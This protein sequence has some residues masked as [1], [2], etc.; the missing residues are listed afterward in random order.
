MIVLPLLERSV[1]SGFPSHGF[2]EDCAAA[3]GASAV[4]RIARETNSLLFIA[5][6][7]AFE[8]GGATLRPAA[9]LQFTTGGDDIPWV[10]V[11]LLPAPFCET[12]EMLPSEYW[13]TVAVFD[14]PP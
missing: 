10:T 12:V 5:S 2:D 11:A 1:I 13:L 7:P 4:A 9:S 14:D 3:G 8:S 6:F